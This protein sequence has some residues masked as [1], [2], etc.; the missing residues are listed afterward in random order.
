VPFGS[1][2]LA[3]QSRRGALNQIERRVS[4]C[5][6]S[7]GAARKTTGAA[8]ALFDQVSI[9]AANS[10]ADVARYTFQ[11]GRGLWR[12]RDPKAVALRDRGVVLNL[13]RVRGAARTNH[14]CKF[15]HDINV[16]I[17]ARYSPDA[18]VVGSQSAR[19]SQMR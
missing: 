1:V 3:L 11:S 8:V 7:Q 13:A 16:S 18:H 12:Q 6:R 4:S 2:L 15:F 9:R 5:A 10:D 14:S 19:P 17:R